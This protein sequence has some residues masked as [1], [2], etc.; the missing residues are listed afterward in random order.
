MA[1]V[2]LTIGPT[3]V[4]S[5]LNV[6]LF[7]VMWMQCILYFTT[8]KQDKR[9]IRLLVW[10]LLVTD[11]VNSAFIV[12]VLYLYTIT[13]FGNIDAAQHQTWPA[14]IAPFL[15]SIISVF[16]QGFFTHRVHVLTSVRPLVVLICIGIF[17]QF[18][19]GMSVSIMS[20]ILPNFSDWGRPQMRIPIVGSLILGAVVDSSITASLT[21]SLQKSKTGFSV[22]DDLVTRLI[23]LTVQTGMMT[24]VVAVID[25]T[26][27]LSSASIPWPFHLVC[28]LT[29][30]KFYTISLM[31]TLNARHSIR[32]ASGQQ[33]AHI[34]TDGNWPTK[35]LHRSAHSTGVV[36]SIQVQVTTDV[37]EEFEL[38]QPP[39]KVAPGDWSDASESTTKHTET[40]IEDTP[41]G[42]YEIQWSRRS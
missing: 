13:N 6:F 27:Y 19:A 31:S 25:L 10:F 4:G 20:N 11:T 24:A 18:V 33:S 7:G 41:R 37:A 16:V 5:I 9:G 28:G 26:L 34:V 38:V 12:Y 8:F 39:V 2:D 15:T 22:T 40:N 36:S 3:L 42:Q 14:T 17:L 1:T 35:D 30:P 21:W 32:H 23:R 29:L